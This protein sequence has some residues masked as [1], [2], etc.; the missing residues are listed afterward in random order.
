MMFEYGTTPRRA[1]PSPARPPDLVKKS[2]CESSNMHLGVP[3]PV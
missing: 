1:A 3:Q 2:K